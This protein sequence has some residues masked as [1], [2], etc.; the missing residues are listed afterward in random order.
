MFQIQL[1]KS[2]HTSILQYQNTLKFIIYDAFL[3][4]L[5]NKY[6]YEVNVLRENTF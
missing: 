3:T 1:L 4:L 5:N 6:F 2:I